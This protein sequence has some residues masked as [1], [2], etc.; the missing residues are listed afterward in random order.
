M[1]NCQREEAQPQSPDR[2]DLTMDMGEEQPSRHLMSTCH[3]M[4]IH[5][6]SMGTEHG[7]LGGGGDK[8]QVCAQ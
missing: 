4:P 5:Q 7:A 1:C 6:I 3:R 8:G 2:P